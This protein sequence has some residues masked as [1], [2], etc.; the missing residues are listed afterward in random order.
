MLILS[1]QKSLLTNNQIEKKIRELEEERSRLSRKCI[2]IEN[3]LKYPEGI[4]SYP[5]EEDEDR[6]WLELYEN[7]IFEIDNEI[8]D[9]R[10]QMKLND[11]KPCE[12]SEK[13]QHYLNKYF[14]QYYNILIDPQMINLVKSINLPIIYKYHNNPMSLS[15]Q[16]G[17]TLI[18]ICEKIRKYLYNE[19][20]V[21]RYHYYVFTGKPYSR[22]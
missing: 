3:N 17:I 10:H 14:D 1:T 8:R 4:Y 2:E 15:K 5:G 18:G 13:Q 22:R 21:N 7:K 19:E 20:L 11:T 6:E 12:L 9:L 16:E